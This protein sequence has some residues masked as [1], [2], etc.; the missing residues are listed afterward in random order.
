MN[1]ITR[2]LTGSA[3]FVAAGACGS[4]DK[5]EHTM[6]LRGSLSSTT[7]P[8]DNTRAVA[9]A[10]TGKRYWAYLSVRGTFTLK[11]PTG[12]AYRVVLA[13]QLP[14][15]GQV[16]IGHVTI[17]GANGPSTWISA[18]LPGVVDLGKLRSGT[19]PPSEAVR[20]QHYGYGGGGGG[21]DDDDD[22]GGD[23]GC[24]SE[25]D[26]HDDRSSDTGGYG[27][28][29]AA[30]SDDDRDD[31]DY[32]Y[33]HDREKC[34]LYEKDGD[35]VDLSPSHE[36]GSR[37]NDDHEDTHEA[38]HASGGYGDTKPCPDTKCGAS[39]PPS[40]GYGN[41]PAGSTCDTSASCTSTCQCVASKCTAGY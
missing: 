35:D 18:R 13:N 25:G 11:V 24:H 28:S 2:V 7:R 36:P 27:K 41:E 6:T 23:Y 15:G 4:P 12:H 3:L 29:T 9:I 21:D 16:K 1:R 14:G 39:A 8:M 30:D 17:A 31:Y 20:T 10:D 33:D 19:R 26:D 5:T 34:D 38:K 37:Y 32:D 40:G 22:H